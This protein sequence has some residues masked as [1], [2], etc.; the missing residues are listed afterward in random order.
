MIRWVWAFLDRPAQRFDACA[1]FW[2]TITGTQLSPRRGDDNQFLTL[3]PDPALFAAA[4]VK[5]QS[6]NGL[7]GVHLD[8]DVDDIPAAVRVALDLNAELVANHPD[9]AVLRSPAGQIFCF[10]PSGRA[11]GHP[12][13]AFRAPDGTLSRLDQVCL[14]IGA[15]DHDVETRFWADLTGWKH[16]PG[17]LAEFSRLRPAEPMPVQLLLQRLGE[18]RPTSAHIDLSSSDI[19]ATAAW[20]ESLGATVVRRHEHWIVMTDPGDAVYCVTARDPKGV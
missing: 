13:P 15:A 20:H 1:T 2:S 12:A 4:G 14:D 5:M 17:R 7:G 9:Y 6:V 3:L 19:E 16:T 11:K 10:T 18:N 8:F